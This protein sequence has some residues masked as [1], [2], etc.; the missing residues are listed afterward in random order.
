MSLN[1]LLNA[2]II[3]C[4]CLS[5]VLPQAGSEA[6]KRK[7]ELEEK[8]LEMLEQ[9]VGEANSLKLPQN[10]AVAYGMLG[11]LFW[12][13]DSKRSKELFRSTAAE[14]N[15]YYLDVEKER[16]E[17]DEKTVEVFDPMDVRAEVLSLVSFRDPE[18]ALELLVQTRPAAIAEAMSRAN[19][20]PTEPANKPGVENARALQEIAIEERFSMMA[21]AAD[22]ERAGTAIKTSLSKGISTG[23]LQLLQVVYRADE[24]KAADLAAAVVSRITEIDL[25]KNTSDLNSTIALLQT[26]NRPAPKLPVQNIKTFA[27]QDAQLK[28]IANKLTSTFLSAPVS[29][30]LTSALSRALPTLEKVVPERSLLLK[31]RDQANKKAQSAPNANARGARPAFDP[32]AS[33]E[34]ILAQA[35]KLPNERDKMASYQNVASRLSQVTDD[36]RA[37]KL[38]DQIGDERLRKT[39]SEQFE[40]ARTSRLIAGDKLE[41]ARRSINL[42]PNRHMRAQRLVSLSLQHVNKKTEADTEIARTLL[43]DAKALTNTDPQDE[44][45]IADVMEL[46]RG[47]VALDQAAAFRLVEP[48]IDQFSE[49]TQATA[50]LS[51]YNKRDRAFKSGELLMR[52]NGN[53]GGLMPFRYINQYQQLGRADIEKMGALADRFSRPDARMLIRLFAL[54]GYVRGNPIP[55]PR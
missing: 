34:E 26:V 12:R 21:A 14:I 35:A 31:Q 13:F 43:N 50:I 23:V 37:K 19:P 11:D 32:N 1:K 2:V 18:L 39:A 10:R 48:V 7:V 45:D 53:A 40:A 54:Q 3:L 25:T 44:D 6:A 55:P 20:A 15:N 5:T 9:T 27:F 29:P 36:A 33:L 17:N 24:K 4:V 47:Y 38:I 51:K 52:V 22:P 46:V 41:E 16:R 49:I 30:A 28:D 42:L 8:A